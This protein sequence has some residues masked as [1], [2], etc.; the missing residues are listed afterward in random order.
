MRH[1]QEPTTTTRGFRAP[2]TRDPA[3]TALLAETGVPAQITTL[4]QLRKLQ[5]QL[6]ELPRT[7]DQQLEPKTAVRPV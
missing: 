1:A 7:A 5:Q 6:A 2:E 4:E 3:A